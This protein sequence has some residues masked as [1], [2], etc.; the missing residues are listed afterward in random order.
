[1]RPRKLL[2]RIA[3]A[4]VWVTARDGSVVSERDEQLLRRVYAAFNARDVR[5]ALAMLHPEVD[6]PNAME[7]GRVRGREG[8]GEYWQR[9]WASFDT[10]V[11]PLAIERGRGGCVV[12]TVRQRVCDL[13]GNVVS[14]ETVE[15][16]YAIS[17]GLIERMD[18]HVA[19]PGDA[20]R[21]S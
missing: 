5:G 20:G 8:V 14:E 16:R 11:Q 6:W 18:V 2:A 4:G 3:R 15:H 1:M 13:A 19:D 17:G 7:C 10:R 21:D 12:V 9:Q